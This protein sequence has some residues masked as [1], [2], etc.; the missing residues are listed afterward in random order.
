MVTETVW[1]LPVPIEVCVTPSESEIENPVLLA[2]IMLSSGVPGE[3]RDTA[4]ITHLLE[5]VGCVATES[6][7]S[8]VRL[9]S[10]V[11]NVAQFKGSFPVSTNWRSR[12]LELLPPVEVRVK[13]GAMLSFSVS[14][15]GSE[16][17]PIE[18]FA[19]PPAIETTS[20][21]EAFPVLV[22]LNVTPVPL[23]TGEV[24]VQPADT[25]RPAMSFKVTDSL[26]VRET[27]TWL[28]M[29]ASLVSE[30]EE[31]A[32]FEVF[33][34]RVKALE[35]TEV[36]EFRFWVAVIDQVPSDRVP[37][38]QLAVPPAPAA[39]VVQVTLLDEAFVDVAVT[40]APWVTPV[41]S[42]VGVLS[43]VALSESLDPESEFTFRSGAL[44]AARPTFAVEDEV[45]V[46]VLKTEESMVTVASSLVRKYLPTSAEAN[47]YVLD[48]APDTVVQ[49]TPSSEDSQVIDL[50]GVG[51]PEK[52]T[53]EVSTEPGTTAAGLTDG[54]AE[55]V[56]VGPEGVITFTS[57]Y[58][59]PASV[60][61]GSPPYS[62]M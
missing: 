40:V 12:V 18:S 7:R 24:L 57:V 55:E 14:V 19:N 62:M 17:L 20:L 61:P 8:F 3:T 42:K 56:A 38:V 36:C 13:V 52:D 4:L 26:K 28:A 27:F 32:G 11:V 35:A 45:A 46:A 1:L 29:F 5:S 59:S 54:A 48:V 47:W 50:V 21:S 23:K 58:A 39:L 43:E 60:S 22:A 31:I 34:A 25:E 51:Y 10:L 41:K 15:L 30:L 9:K 33:T 6:I 44:R 53:P 16:V 49:L 37:K 2:A